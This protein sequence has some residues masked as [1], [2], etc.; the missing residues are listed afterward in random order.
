MDKIIFASTNTNKIADLAPIFRSFNIEIIPAP[1]GG[2]DVLE[3]ANTYHG[4]ALLKARAYSAWLN[5]PCLADDSGIEFAALN[6]EPGVLSARFLPHIRT[7]EERNLE[8]LKMLETAED[9]TC[10]MVS[11]LCLCIDR[12]VYLL[13]EGV[14]RGRLPYEPR[15]QNGWG[16]DPI[17]EVSDNDTNYTMAEIRDR[18]K[19]QS[20]LDTHR[21]RAAHKLLTMI[22]RMD[23]NHRVS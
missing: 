1:E 22:G 17:F 4:N 10:R 5:A 16:Y 7:S 3:Y 21:T 13:G 12:D 20:I 11:V 15:G 23:R 9:R 8:I 19:P 2:P 14:I 6:N 18:A